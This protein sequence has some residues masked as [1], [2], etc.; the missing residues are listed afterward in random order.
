MNEANIVQFIFNLFVQ[1]SE[2]I[3]NY[4]SPEIPQEVKNRIARMGI[5]TMLKMVRHVTCW[6]SAASDYS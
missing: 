6:I 5:E 1:E 4:L 3:S 2:P